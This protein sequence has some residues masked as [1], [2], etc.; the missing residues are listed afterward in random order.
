MPLISNEWKQSLTATEFEYHCE[1]VSLFDIAFYEKSGKI[2]KRDIN[3]GLLLSHTVIVYDKEDD[4]KNPKAAVSVNV[5]KIDLRAKPVFIH[6]GNY[7]K[8]ID[9]VEADIFDNTIETLKICAIQNGD[10]FY[11]YQTQYP[12]NWAPGIK[13]FE[14]EAFTKYTNTD[15][16]FKKNENSYS[17][18]T[19][20]IN[21]ADRLEDK[22]NIILANNN[23]IFKSKYLSTFPNLDAYNG[24]YVPY[25]SPIF[26][27]L[28]KDFYQI[29][30]SSFD[31]NNVIVKAG[32]YIEIDNAV[33]LYMLKH[34]Y[35]SIL[36][37]FYADII[38]YK[39][40]NQELA[41][42]SDVVHKNLILSSTNGKF[43][44]D[45]FSD[46]NIDSAIKNAHYIPTTTPL[47]DHYSKIL[48]KNNGNLTE[49]SYAKYVKDEIFEES[50]R[51]LLGGLFTVPFEDGDSDNG[52]TF[53]SV[54]LD[55]TKPPVYYDPDSRHGIDSYKDDAPIVVPKDGNLLVD[56][57]IFSTTIDEIWEAIKRIE[58]GRK[59]DKEPDGTMS[60]SDEIGYPYASNEKYK[61][62]FDTRPFNAKKYELDGYVGDP[63]Q[64]E[65]D[66]SA[67]P[68]SFEIKS[69]VNDPDSIYYN[70]IN[71][72]KS[73]LKKDF[74]FNKDELKD[75]DKILEKVENVSMSMPSD[76]AYSLR[77]LESLLRGLQFNLA[78]I[79]NYAEKY[80]VRIGSI[81]KILNAGKPFETAGTLNRL[82]REYDGTNNTSYQ[83][84]ASLTPIT[85]ER[86]GKDQ[87]DVPSYSVFLSA[88]GTWQ[89]VSQCMRLRIVDEEF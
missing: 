20:G 18:C 68:I 64:I 22:K 61:T 48:F 27:K 1:N 24:L 73:L 58:F 86:F 21:E 46:D 85:K 3:N 32:D 19:Y 35:I 88:A 5:P 17:D 23:P 76:K 75:L 79:V 72:I 65:Y 49:K 33:L 34:C 25:D 80:F 37:A 63:L 36:C 4:K 54:I 13:I 59:P 9:N 43:E 84:S 45:E 67:S 78:Y 31:L 82:H 62:D 28:F 60:K 66:Q 30:N 55:E 52:K 53:T 7:G 47:V 14:H 40:F 6:S 44:F 11:N 8:Y 41:P 57:R 77:E 29:Q 42:T 74:N 50:N 83:G 2:Y 56:G 51:K 71:E 87:D 38:D 15:S 16:F 39:D 70:V 81:G 26:N 12:N 10:L 69:F 89:S